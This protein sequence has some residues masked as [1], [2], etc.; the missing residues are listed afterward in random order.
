MVKPDKLLKIGEETRLLGVST[1][2]VRLY[3]KQGRIV[4]SLTPSG[5]RSLLDT[6]KGKL[7]G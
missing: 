5:Q 3:V 7:D 2:R 1:S 6:A 4:C